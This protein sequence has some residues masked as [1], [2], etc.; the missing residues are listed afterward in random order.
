MIGRQFQMYGKDV[1]GLTMIY[2]RFAVKHL[3]RT[4]EVVGDAASQQVA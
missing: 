2:A 1:N 4:V 3:Y